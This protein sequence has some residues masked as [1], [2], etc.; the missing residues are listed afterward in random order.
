MAAWA[1]ITF[2]CYLR[3]SELGRVTRE[4]IIPPTPGT[5]VT[6]WAI[7]LHPSEEEVSSK[8]R[9]YDETGVLDLPDFGFLNDVLAYLRRAT[10]P[11][12]P[13]FAF[14][15]ADLVRNF[16][17]AAARAGVEC[18]RPE[19]YMLRHSGASHD[20]ARQL[21]SLQEIKLRGRW[22]CDSSVRRYQKE[23]R[24]GEQ[25]QRLPAA[26]RARA[27]SAVLALPRAL[28]RPSL[29]PWPPGVP[30]SSSRRSF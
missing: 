16:R 4:M 7:V 25:L 6:N 18:L 11:G 29:A 20:R 19:L 23:G 8:T 15:H 24:V 27:I 28:A 5:Q 26:V 10:P 2:H 21:R 9:E 14:A 12:Q 30:A 17:Q 1:A 22:H 3:P 13:V